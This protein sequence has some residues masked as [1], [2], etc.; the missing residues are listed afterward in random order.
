MSNIDLLKKW[1]HCFLKL[2]FGHLPDRY[3]FYFFL[4]FILYLFMLLVFND[5]ERSVDMN[6]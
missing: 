3:R 4:N 5:A 2:R 1:G 6:L